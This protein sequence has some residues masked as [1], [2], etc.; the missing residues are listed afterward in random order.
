[1]HGCACKEQ[2]V[3][4]AAP[5][6]LQHTSVLS[7]EGTGRASKGSETITM[8]VLHPSAKEREGGEGG[9]ERGREMERGGE[10]GREGGRGREREREGQ[11]EVRLEN[12]R[13]KLILNLA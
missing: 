4:T 3:Y 13:K 5:P 8:R 7:E 6:T 2:A 12:S 1:M 11:A 10:G 9:G